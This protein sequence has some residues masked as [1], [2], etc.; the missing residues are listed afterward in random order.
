M[1]TCGSEFVHVTVSPTNTVTDEGEKVRSE[2]VTDW[3]AASADPA[4]ASAARTTATQDAR[5]I[6]ARS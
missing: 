2:I 1:W 6:R 5:I 4:P 3:L